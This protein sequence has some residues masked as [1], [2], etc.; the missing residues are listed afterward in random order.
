MITGEREIMKNLT[1]AIKVMSKT[2]VEA[3]NEIGER[4]VA[5]IKDNSP[6]ISGRLR[7]SMSYTTNGKVVDPLGAD[8]PQDKLKPLKSN[9]EVAIGT[10]V[11]YAAR[12]EYMSNNGSEGYMLRSYKQLKKQAEQIIKSV[13]KK[14]GF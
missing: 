14:R 11:V 12:V 4:G 10:N 6:V 13:F 2:R 8:K 5:I 3:L 1:K 9:E 7:N